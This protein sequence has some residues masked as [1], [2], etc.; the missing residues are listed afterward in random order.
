MI[1]LSWKMPLLQCSKNELEMISLLPL[2]TFPWNVF[3]AFCS[4]HPYKFILVRSSHVAGSQSEIWEWKWKRHQ[5]LTHSPEE[6]RTKQ[7]V[8]A[9]GPGQGTAGGI[10]GF[11]SHPCYCSDATSRANES[12]ER[13]D[14]ITLP[15]P[16]HHSY[17][18]LKRIIKAHGA[19]TG[20]MQNQEE[21]IS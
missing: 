3:K 7:A 11:P 13:R 18:R 4:W 8:Q 12:N 5:V 19:W 14:P 16:G 9:V 1:F 15:W 21:F 17:I 10:C 20:E 6:F 2:W